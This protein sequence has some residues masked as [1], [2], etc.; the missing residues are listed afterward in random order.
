MSA[1]PDLNASPATPLE[2]LGT[3]L[4]EAR[5]SRG[6]ER[7]ALAAQLHMGDEQ[8]Q[9]LEEA[10]TARLPETVF[11]IAQSRRVARALGV[12]IDPLIAPLKQGGSEVKPA[13]PVQAPQLNETRR[14][15]GLPLAW[16]GAL[17]LLAALGGAGIWGWKM[18]GRQGQ[19]SARSQAQAQAS[20]RPVRPTPAAPPAASSLQ[21]SSAEPSWLTVEAANGKIL[22]EGLFRGSRRFPIGPGLK[23]R[24]GR[25]DLVQASLG[26][27]AGKPLG[28]ID[29]ITWVRFGPGAPAPTP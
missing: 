11:V 2:R 23:V 26:A 24:A 6:L 3:T 19:G 20:V 29:Q 7:A 8:L 14:V 10:N 5:L 17:V 18:I 15:Q 12:D 21:L 25:P 4:R 13:A 1:S 22:Y 27:E 28:K 9:A 16:L